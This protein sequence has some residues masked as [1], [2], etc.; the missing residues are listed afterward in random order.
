MSG[1]NARRAAVLAGL[2]LALGIATGAAAKGPVGLQGWLAGGYHRAITLDD[3]GLDLRAGGDLKLGFIG[4]GVSGRFGTDRFDKQGTTRG[5]VYGDFTLFIPIPV[6]RPYL[7]V[8]AGPVWARQ[9][10]G[11]GAPPRVGLHQGVG[12]DVLIPQHVAIGVL[13]DLDENISR[14]GA[15]TE[16]GLTG[17]VVFKLRL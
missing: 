11:A 10:D 2:V 3:N 14:E 12:V 5:A 8:G 7:R 4:L 6:V 17:L 9:L 13:V 16:V 1:T 15:P